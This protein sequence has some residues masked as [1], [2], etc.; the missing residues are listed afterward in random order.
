MEWL[1]MMNN[2]DA[3]KL[4]SNHVGVHMEQHSSTFGL[5][6]QVSN[7]NNKLQTKTGP[8]NASPPKIPLYQPQ[9]DAHFLTNE[10][11]ALAEQ[12]CIFYRETVWKTHLHM[13]LPSCHTYMGTKVSNMDQYS[14]SHLLGKKAIT[15]KKC[16]SGL[17]WTAI[18]TQ[19]HD[20]N[21]SGDFDSC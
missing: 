14:V 6:L 3:Q 18:S 12:M 5:L 8:S 15:R 11:H 2:T 19:H 9:A 16:A 13:I 20:R 4:T 10:T 1:L 7:T 17:L 21:T